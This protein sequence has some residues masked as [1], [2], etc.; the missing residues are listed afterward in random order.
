MF[1]WS[2]YQSTAVNHLCCCFLEPARILEKAVSINVTAGESATLEC[3]VSGSP[4]LKFKWFKDQKEVVS[5]RK[6]R[7][8]VKDTTVALKIL[9]AD[10][11][12]T[13]EYRMELSNKV[14]KDQCSC[15][16]TVI[17]QSQAETLA[18]IAWSPSVVKNLIS[19]LI[20]CADRA[21]PPSFT[22]TLKKV[23]GRA[24]S[25]ETMECRI[26][27]SQPLLV[28][29][30]KDGQE[31]F[32]LGRHKVDFSDGKASLTIASLEQSDSGLYTC[33]ASNIAGEKE[34]SSALSIKGQQFS[35]RS[36][37]SLVDYRINS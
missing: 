4:E 33:R 14:G 22:R 23:D 5:G 27:G 24:G 15:S 7:M 28:S 1:R 13:A 2:Q 20:P 6:Y 25:Y 21:V 18:R 3:R 16:V 30:F 10:K 37:H 29:W 12:D 9:S 19:D 8:L 31:I 11:G 35:S 26:S 36:S 17:G 34:T 32:S